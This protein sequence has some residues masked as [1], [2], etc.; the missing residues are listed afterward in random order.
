MHTVAVELDQI[1]RTQHT[2]IYKAVIIKLYLNY[3]MYT[4]ISMVHVAY[5]SY[6]TIQ[7]YTWICLQQQKLWPDG[8]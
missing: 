7:H 3:Q 2:N 6:I 5:K 4:T 8:I 1:N